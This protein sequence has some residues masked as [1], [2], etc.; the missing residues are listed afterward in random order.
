M[1]SGAGLSQKK[2]M[3]FLVQLVCQTLTCLLEKEV[4]HSELRS[5]IQ[6]LSAALPE[7]DDRMPSFFDASSAAGA[8]P[9][10]TSTPATATRSVAAILSTP[11][12]P[13]VLPDLRLTETP[14]PATASH[15]ARP[16]AATEMTHDSEAMQAVLDHAPHDEDTENELTKSLEEMENIIA[17]TR[18]VGATLSPAVLA[19]TKPSLMM[20]RVDLG[21]APAIAST[22]LGSAQA[23]GLELRAHKQALD[24]Q[25]AEFSGTSATDLLFLT[26]TTP[27][28]TYSGVL[29]AAE[30]ANQT[31]DL[32]SQSFHQP[33]AVTTRND[34]TDSYEDMIDRLSSKFTAMHTY[35]A[36]NHPTQS[37]QPSMV[38]PLPQPPT[39]VAK[40]VN[41][42]AQ[43]VRMENGQVRLKSGKKVEAHF[44]TNKELFPPTPER[45][46]R[47]FDAT[48]G[49][50]LLC[51]KRLG[52]NLSLSL[53]AAT[54]ASDVEAAK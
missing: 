24:A 31:F 50:Y 43:T 25:I 13:S 46:P 32:Y 26:P 16:M 49:S 22:P 4:E 52:T 27:H 42:L 29:A 51:H 21:T 37:E 36:R 34:L 14:L 8:T 9:A 15:S 38:M 6:L 23:A 28:A 53:F 48:N 19:F 5:R 1:A 40:S 44:V 35:G 17:H 41:P 20:G 30:R 2:V 7:E 10:T 12:R 54:V 39:P 3:R 47:V 45:D 18:Q 33:R 11:T